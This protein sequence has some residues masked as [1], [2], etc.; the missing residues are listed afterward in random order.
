[1]GT[2]GEAIRAPAALFRRNGVRETDR[3]DRQD[4]EILDL[5][6]SDAKSTQSE[7]AEKVGL[8]VQ[9]VSE[10]LRKLEGRGVIRRYVALLDARRLG[11]DI[12]AFVS[13]LLDHPTHDAM[14]QAAMASLPEVLECHHVVGPFSYLLKVK[15]EDTA[16]LE[17]LLAHRIKAIG[18]VSQT[19][20]VVV[21][22][23]SKEETAIDIP[24]PRATERRAAGAR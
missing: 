3:F 18:G 2:I 12:T 14:F 24:L 10:R 20:T 22:S 6:Q 16:A 19:V 4:L 7:I 21:L 15:V 17:K 11:K 13:V 5:V 23:T 1:V 8:S 9:A